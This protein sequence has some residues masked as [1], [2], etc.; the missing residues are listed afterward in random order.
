L[1]IIDGMVIPLDHTHDPERRSWLASANLPGAEFPVQNLPCGTFV[2]QGREHAGV[3]IG[4]AIVD[5]CAVVAARLLRGDA[6]DAAYAICVRGLG[7]LFELE[8]AAR[9]ALRSGL[10]ELLAAGGPDASGAEASAGEWLV[11]QQSVSLILPTMPVAFT[12]Y[13]ASLHHIRRLAGAAAEL[14]PWRHLPVGYNGRASSVRVS[15]ASVRR[16]WGQHAAADGVVVYAPEPKL[17]FELELGVW[18]GR[19]TTLGQRVGV[20]DAARAVAGYCL[21]ND[22]SARA[23]QRF[24]MALGPFLGKSFSTS[25]SPWVVTAEALAPFRTAAPPRG[26][27]DPAVPEHLSSASDQRSGGLCVE[28]SAYLDTEEMR[29]ARLPAHCITRTCTTDL[30]WTVAQL[31]AH[32]TS[33]GCNLCNGELVATGTVSGPEPGARA[34]LAEYGP[35]EVIEL[36]SGERRRWLEDGD[37]VT[38]VGW[39]RR[40]GFVPIG[41]GHCVGIIS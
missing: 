23:I 7:E 1:S 21:V 13:C 5:L 18:V 12:D 19:S 38:L 15:G 24:E 35:D 36:P 3:A 28:L 17:D 27:G 16:P 25:V 14:P 32:Q 40:E 6:H 10:F 39:A 8:P 31:I 4:D 26:P 33:N 41:F 30:F 9:S 2:R 20:D 11:P 29:R 34:C 22:W 37:A